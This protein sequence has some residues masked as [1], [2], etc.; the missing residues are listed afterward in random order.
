MNNDNEQ[1]VV[2]NNKIIKNN[3]TEIIVERRLKNMGVLVLANSQPYTD[4]HGAF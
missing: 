3:I 2:D 4:G 1:I